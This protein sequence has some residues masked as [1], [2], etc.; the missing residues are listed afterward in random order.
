MR[1]YYSASL[2]PSIS[3]LLDI[4]SCGRYVEQSQQHIPV[5]RLIEELGLDAI[6]D[7]HHVMAVNSNTQSLGIR[8]FVAPFGKLTGRQRGVQLLGHSIAE[9]RGGNIRA[10][11]LTHIMVQHPLLNAF[12]PVNT[13]LAGNLALGTPGRHIDFRVAASELSGLLSSHTEAVAKVHGDAVFLYRHIL[14]R[15]EQNSDLL[16]RLYNK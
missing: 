15:D 11:L 1:R 4:L 7:L 14:H 8:L 3:V 5:L 12:E 2:D 9:G 10:Q 13:Q 16:M 6:V